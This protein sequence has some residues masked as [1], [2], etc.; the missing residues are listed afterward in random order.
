MFICSIT[1]ELLVSPCSP[2]MTGM[3]IY[4]HPASEDFVLERIFH[5]MSD[6]VRLEIVRQLAQV[7]SASCGDLDRG[8]P[9]SSMSHHY[10]ILREAGLMK[11]LVEGTVHSNTLRK[12]E[13]DLRFP[14][15]MNAILKQGG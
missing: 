11:T 4:S 10:R 14:G 12:S 15:L 1:I 6:P 2:R 3:R 7:K 13:L 9:K 8:R 5:A